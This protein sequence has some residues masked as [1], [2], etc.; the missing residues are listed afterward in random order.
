MGK[1][2]AIY[3]Y[4]NINLRI[5]DLKNNIYILMFININ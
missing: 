1:K 5:N 4:S 3:D 2:L